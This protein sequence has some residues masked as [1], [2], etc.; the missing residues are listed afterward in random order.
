[1]R[2]KQHLLNSLWPLLLALSLAQGALAQQAERRVALIVGNSQYVSVPKLDNP[3][4]D[5]LLMAE[6]LA[7]LG[8]TVVG[9][10]AQLDLDK[11]AFEKAVQAFGKAIQGANVALF[12][13]AGHG[14]QIR[15]SNYLVPVN[16]NPTREADADFQ[17]LNVDLILRQMEASSTRLNMVVLDACRNNPFSGSGVRASG[18]GL[19]QM[20]AP[21]G[22]LIAYAT[23]PGNVAQDGDGGHSPYTAALARAVRAPGLDIFSVFNEVGLAVKKITGGAQQPWV[24][25]SPLEGKFYFAG[26]TGDAKLPALPPIVVATAPSSTS[27][28]LVRSSGPA[29]RSTPQTLSADEAKVMLVMRD[30]YRAGWHTQGKG[31]PHKYDTQAHAGALVVVDHGTQLMWQRSGSGRIV[32]GGFKGAGQYVQELNTKRMGG[33]D[34]WRLP[35]LEE[36]MSLMTP[37]AAGQA[38]ETS[39]GKAINH[40][41]SAFESGGTYFIWTSDTVSADRGWVVYYVDGVCNTETL[42]YSAYVRA[43][44]SVK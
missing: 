8:F 33:F 19:A 22:T 36:A 41:A 29:L 10:K 27:S 30:F 31:G 1:M 13:Y 35:T 26:A 21:E 39:G 6:T 9:G 43:V 28:T 2:L 3:G 23:Q 11:P 17:L 40:I 44:R 25:S 4:P 14:L 20:Q 5:A 38:M 7:A 42:Q 24:S 16:A 37:P 12:Y 32:Q 18:G 34:D 15:G